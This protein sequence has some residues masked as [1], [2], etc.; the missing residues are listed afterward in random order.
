MGQKSSRTLQGDCGWVRG[1]LRPQVPELAPSFALT[2]WDSSRLSYAEAMNS[3]LSH[4]EFTW[5]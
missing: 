2:P 1:D 4:A 3:A 5:A